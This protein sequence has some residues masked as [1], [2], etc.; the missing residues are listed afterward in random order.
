MHV[1]VVLL[2]GVLFIKQIFNGPSCA[3]GAVLG[4]VS[5]NKAV[6]ALT[7]LLFCIQAAGK[8]ADLEQKPATLCPGQAGVGQGQ[9]LSGAPPGWSARMQLYGGRKNKQCPGPTGDRGREGARP[10]RTERGS[11]GLGFAQDSPDFALEVPHPEKTQSQANWDSWS[12]Y[13]G[14]ELKT[15]PAYPGA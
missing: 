2:L 13:L 3:P 10:S 9:G 12:P 5:V 1:C 15:P 4:T 14:L 6:S 7:K 8:C 11:Q